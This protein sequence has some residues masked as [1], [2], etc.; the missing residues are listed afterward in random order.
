MHEL[1][2]YISRIVRENSKSWNKSKKSAD[3]VCT[4][5]V[6]QCNATASTSFLSPPGVGL[7]LNVGGPTV[8]SGKKADDANSYCSVM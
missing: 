5:L 1:Q 4:G 7:K 3:T 8:E 6:T 2:S